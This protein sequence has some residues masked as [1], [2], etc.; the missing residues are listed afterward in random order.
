VNSSQYRDIVV[1]AAS[2]GG[3]EALRDLLSRLPADLPASV[4]VVLHIPATSGGALASILDRSG[5]LAAATARDG[6]TLRPGRVYVAP[7]DR[8]LL[9]NDGKTE[10]S[11]GPKQ[12][13]HRPAADPLFSSAAAVHGR[14]VI[15]VVLSG[16]LDD[17]AVGAAAIERCGGLVIIQDP[18]ES[19]YPGMPRAAL[20]ATRHAHVLPI[21]AIA[22][23]I[24]REC[25]QPMTDAVTAVSPDTSDILTETTDEPDPAHEAEMLTRT[26]PVADD[27][28]GDW[29]GLS[30]PECSGPLNYSPRSEPRRYECR[31]GHGWSPASLL[32][33][34]SSAVEQA[35][36]V[37][38]LRLDERAR[39]TQSMA[40]EADKRN[41]PLSAARFREA[42]REAE[43]AL[44]TIRGLLERIAA[45]APQDDET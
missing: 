17:G 43:D 12:N 34:H 3:I 22:S 31:L 21:P 26:T 6:E 32:D 4:L 13:G 5:P 42:T 41:H 33:G 30:C 2:A 37:A 15:G 23:M 40:E 38:A 7:P 27:P 11:G 20:S 16:T 36:W 19:A 10:L 28:P 24:I 45:N 14:R 35:L 44:L 8:H 39:L 29:S 9:I 1:M 25:K 18:T